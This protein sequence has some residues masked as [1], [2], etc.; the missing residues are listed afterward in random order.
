MQEPILTLV[1]ITPLDPVTGARVLIHAAQANDRRCTGLGGAQWVPAL[2]KGPSTAIKLFDGDFS[3]AVQVSG[4]SLPLNMNQL[5]KVYTVADRY[6]WAGAKVEIFAGRLSQAWPWGA[7]FIGRVKTYSREGDVITFACEADSEPFDADVLNKTYAGTSEAEG[8]A[9]LKGQLKPLIIGHVRNVV[10]VLINSTDYVYQ[11][12]GYGA[13]EEVSE[14]FERGSSF[15]SAV[16]D[17]PDYIS[18]V[19]AD[20]P[21]GQFATCLAE[22]LVRLGAPAAGLITGDVKG[23]A[24]DGVTP[25]LTGDAIAAIAD[26]AGVPR[27]RIESSAL[28]G[29]NTAAPYPINLA[30]NEQ[31]S[32]VDLV[33]RL[34]LP[35]NVQAGISLTGQLFARVIT[36]DGDPSITLDAQGRS[37]PQVIGRPDEMTVS[38]PYWKIIMGAARCWRVQ[39]SDE[40]AFNSPIVD[41]GDFNPTTQ[42]R[43]G[44]I[45]TLPD[46]RRFLYI[47]ETPSTGNE[48]PDATYWEQ[49]GG[50]VTGDT[51][52]VIYRKSSSQPS[53]PADS[54]GIPSGWY[55]DVGDLPAGS[56]PV[57]A[58]YGL[59]QAGATQYVWQTPYS[60]NI[61]KRVYDGLKN[62]GDVEDGK[63]DTSS[64]VGGAISA[65]STTAGSDTYVAAGATT[66]IME[67]SLI[68]IGDA[69]Y[70]SAYIL[71]FAEMDGG[72]QI[73]IGG[74]MFLDIDTGSGFV[75]A[76]TTRGGV[77]STDGN[78][79][80]KIPLLAGETVSGVQQIRVRM[81]VLSFAMPLQSSARAFT[82]RNPQIVVFGAKR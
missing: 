62:N 17:Y 75:Q 71:I 68:T 57:W 15:G 53:R 31:T 66:T 16:A 29:I 18:L 36:M 50:V 5:R 22:G 37:L 76:A 28:S 49:I 33:R 70:G 51:S 11:F 41:R 23:H 12:H 25:R 13:I 39:S 43:E 77:L 6:R 47:A 1:R 20:V 46:G 56:T 78:T 55:D 72:T 32:F 81:R 34:A 52:N 30:L 4:A 24:V 80:C 79:L 48:P 73:D 2:T 9:D 65:P 27:D 63:V 21:K 38:A 67:T 61:D 54:S 64:V 7:H 35:C 42:Y 8:G 3:N 58:C 82:I 45:V 59:K 40:I 44:E 60:I 19:N 69:T 14:L 26:I 74:Q 10:P